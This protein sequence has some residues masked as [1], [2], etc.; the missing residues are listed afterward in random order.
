MQKS[1]F[2]IIQHLIFKRYFYFNSFY[3]ASFKYLIILMIRLIGWINKLKSA[4]F[5][6]AMAYLGIVCCSESSKN[7]E[8]QFHL[9][10]LII[11]LDF[12]L[13]LPFLFLLIGDLKEPFLGLALLCWLTR[14]LSLI[15]TECPLLSIKLMGQ[16]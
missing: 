2:Y 7:L 5:N 9:H 12:E 8:F 15:R 10:H 14:T 16:N 3:C 13:L 4:A 1:E 11:I 6:R